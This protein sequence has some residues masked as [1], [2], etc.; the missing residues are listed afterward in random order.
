MQSYTWTLFKPGVQ[1]LIVKPPVTKQQSYLP[2]FHRR[3]SS[4]ESIWCFPFFSSGVSQRT[5]AGQLVLETG[6]SVWTWWRIL[7]TVSAKG[8]QAL[9]SCFLSSLRKNYSHSFYSNSF[10]L[11]GGSNRDSKLWKLFPLVVA[12]SL[13]ELPLKPLHV[14]QAGQD[15]LGDLW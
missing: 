12:C 1:Y 2:S 13:E 9:C 15:Y 7:T 14:G 11:F 8:C 4:L 5:S 3:K 6:N 10:L